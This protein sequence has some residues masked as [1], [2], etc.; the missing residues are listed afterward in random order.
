MPRGDEIGKL[1]LMGDDMDDVGY[2]RSSYDEDEED[3]Y[4]LPSE[5]G[6]SLWDSADD[7]DEEDDDDDEGDSFEDELTEDEDDE[8]RKSVV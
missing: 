3:G 6:D 5:G 8:D 2:G 7:D 4:G 1:H